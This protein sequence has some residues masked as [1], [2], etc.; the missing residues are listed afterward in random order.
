MHQSSV[1][2][3]FAEHNEPTAAI[4]HAQDTTEDTHALFPLVC[5]VSG[6]ILAGIVLLPIIGQGGKTVVG[7]SDNVRIL[8][9]GGATFFG[10]IPVRSGSGLGAG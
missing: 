4:A 6:Y 9:S 1:A 8:E 10:P 3:R 2:K 5:D 7:R